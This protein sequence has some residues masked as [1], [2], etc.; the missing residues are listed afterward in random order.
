MYLSDGRYRVIGELGSGGFGSVY[1]AEDQTLRKM[2]AIKKI[3][4][5]LL[6]EAAEAE[7]SVLTRASHPGIVRITD[8]FRTDG[9][10]YIVMDHVKGMNLSKLIRSG[11]KIPEKTLFMWIIEICDAVSY[12]HGMSPPVI[13]RDLKP[14]NIMVR[15]EGHIILI[16]F[17]AA[18]VSKGTPEDYV[19]GS[20]G[21]MAPEQ[22]TQ[23]K[24]DERSDIFSLGRVIAFAAGDKKTFGL[25]YV[26][27][28]CT[29]SDPD[30]R[31][32]NAGQIKRDILILS[33]LGKSAIVLIIIL[34]IGLFITVNT[35]K[36][37]EEL[38]AAAAAEQA[39]SQAL[40]CF[41]DLKDYED[42]ARYLKNV[43]E[44]TYPESRYYLQ[45][46]TMLSG[47]SSD[48]TE[49][50][51]ILEEFCSFNESSA[52]EI[53]ADRYIKNTLC[54]AKTY[55]SSD[56][57]GEGY[58]KAEKTLKKALCGG[59]KDKI[60]AGYE[61]ETIRLM[62]NSLISEGRLNEEKKKAKYEEAISF[63]SRLERLDEDAGDSDSAVR[64]ITDTALLYTEIKEY[65]KALEAYA[66]AEREYPGNA[67]LGYIQHILLLMRCERPKAEIE[68]VW[69]TA[70]E[71][72]ITRDEDYEIVKERM[73]AYDKDI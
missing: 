14:D 34:I 59:Y 66:R 49:L 15:P 3:P 65:D 19:C 16:D 18:S 4:E 35:I 38:N 73:D 72:G 54:I 27:K 70:L 1:L 26:V 17:G 6:K 58:E 62:I 68:R 47:A 30:R 2:W 56:E 61:A 9:H 43:P 45:I 46:S 48:R 10:I 21:Y 36:E 52:S 22:L 29:A 32:K 8:V 71:A 5:G 23:G 50:W 51:E 28:R 60:S 57:K 42:T 40:M 7:L 69:E 33:N 39:Y 12:L 64:D 37:T 41:Y 67:K 55:I 63:L 25:N 24:T 20:K 44:E 13:I 53:G 31:Y 11:I